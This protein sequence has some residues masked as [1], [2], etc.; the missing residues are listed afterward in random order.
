M[1]REPAILGIVHP[2]IA[3]PIAKAVSERQVTIEAGAGGGSCSTAPMETFT[4]SL[5]ATAG[6]CNSWRMQQ[7]AHA[8]TGACNNRFRRHLLHHLARISPIHLA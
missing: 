6:A 1:R 3:Q 4:V 8:T 5:C 7:L 2:S